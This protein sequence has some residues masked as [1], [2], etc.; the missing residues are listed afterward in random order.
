MTPLPPKVLWEPQPGPQTSFIQC[1]VFEI[2]FGGARGGGKTE[3][4]IG[5]WLSAGERRVVITS[6]PPRPLPQHRN[7]GSSR[8]Y[9]LTRSIS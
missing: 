1:P 5:D 7:V 6:G 9:Q 3:A 4:S 8:L 2:F